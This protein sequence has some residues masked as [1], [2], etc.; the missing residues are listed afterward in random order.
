ME[1]A[2]GRLTVRPR[3]ISLLANDPAQD[4]ISSMLTDAG[5]QTAEAEDEFWPRLL[6]LIDEGRVVPV[7]GPDLLTFRKNGQK[8]D[9]F[10]YTL[11][12]ERLANELKDPI[13]DPAKAGLYEVAGRYI[14]EGGARPDLREK[15]RKGL[16]EFL[17]QTLAE[18]LIP[19]GPI[20]PS[21]PLQQLA[22][23]SSLKLFVTTTFDPLLRMA[24]DNER[25]LIQRSE[26]T[27]VVAFSPDEGVDLD[28]DLDETCRP[29]V[30]HLFG[31]VSAAPRFAVTE[32]DALEVFYAL[33]S[34]VP[35]PKNLLARLRGRQ[36]LLIG[37]QFPDWLARFFLRI[38]R[39]KGKRL[40]QTYDLPEVIANQHGD[41]S[42]EVFLK[43]F[44]VD[45]HLFKGGA[46]QFVA[47]LAERW[48]ARHPGV[49]ADGAPPGSVFVSYASEDRSAVEVFCEELTREGIPFWFDRRELRPG[50]LYRNKIRLNI[51]NC[52]VFVPFLSPH[53]QT[54]EDRFF[55]F[56]WKVAQ[57]QEVVGTA[58]FLD[59]FVVPVLYEDIEDRS[60]LPEFI[61]ERHWHRLH[62]G[63]LD[64]QLVKVLRQAVREVRKARGWSSG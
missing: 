20:G 33:Q 31:Q 44:G 24:L 37:N 34:E 5:I 48:K 25:H 17:N 45:T 26:Q 59:K 62:F 14:A 64:P 47:E 43:R 56:E 8:E 6:N 1:R 9:Q 38:A 2:G 19:R 10:L 15:R 18:H 29:V 4:K 51:E 61:R 30:F 60:V 16:Y 23:I 42:F 35:G 27:K 21:E 46:A 63:R 57:E 50:D 12:A 39:G 3:S 54:L 58:P 7:I 55:K 40:W 13:E 28:A 22:R 52:A 32:E 41:P 49:A 36:I 53:V 11:L